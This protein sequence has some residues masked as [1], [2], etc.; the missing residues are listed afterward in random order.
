MRFAW[1]ALSQPVECDAQ[2]RASTMMVRARV[3]TTAYT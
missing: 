1:N 2:R 3:Q